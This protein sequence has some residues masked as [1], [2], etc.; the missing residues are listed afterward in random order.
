MPRSARENSS[1]TGQPK[2]R[3]KAVEN[4]GDKSDPPIQGM[5]YVQ[6]KGKRAILPVERESQARQYYQ[7]KGKAQYYHW[8]GKAS[9]GNIS[10]CNAHPRELEV[11]C[12]HRRRVTSKFMC[13]ATPFMSEDQTLANNSELIRATAKNAGGPPNQEWES[14]SSCV[15]DGTQPQRP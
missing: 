7:R 1:A 2:S 5:R 6:W 11:K 8:K 14:C 4:R 10:S 13:L 15:L 12:I 9:P 3:Q